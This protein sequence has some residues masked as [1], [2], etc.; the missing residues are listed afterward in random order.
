MIGSLAEVTLGAL[1]HVIGFGGTALIASL[2][3][4]VLSPSNN[5]ALGVSN[6][7]RS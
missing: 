7:P 2:P 4:T 3:I 1:G 5:T 6:H